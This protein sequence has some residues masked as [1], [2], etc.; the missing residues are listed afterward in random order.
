MRTDIIQVHSD[1]LGKYL[2]R[3]S[4]TVVKVLVLTV[5]IC[6]EIKK[7]Y[8]SKND[9]VEKKATT[10][11]TVLCVCAFEYTMFRPCNRHQTKFH[12]DVC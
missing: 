9:V 11:L 5:Y 10:K 1:L 8:D 2:C 12:F 4:T 6:I 7:K 3:T